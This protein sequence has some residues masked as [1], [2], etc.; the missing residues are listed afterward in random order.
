MT[1]HESSDAYPPAH[2]DRAFWD[3]RYREAYTARPASAL[4][5]RWVDRLT[6]GRALDLACG[7]G[8]N[9]LV[10]AA[11]GWQVLGV[12]IS[13][14]GL[15]LARDEARRRGIQL[16]LLAADVNR[17]RWPRAHFDLVTVFRFLDR[18][19]CAQMAATLR[20]GGVLIYETFTVAQRDY[21][22]GPRS[23]AMLLQSGELP[24]LFPALDVLEYDEDVFMEGGRPR[25]LARLV[26]RAPQETTILDSQ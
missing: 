17:W 23:D 16:D 26:A 5:Q 21:E 19:L 9:A 13:P 4:L 3:V 18:T 10:L 15:H 1:H 12:D 8:R 14:V 24:K 22:G 25:A 20:P 11:H 2:L 6:P 7:A